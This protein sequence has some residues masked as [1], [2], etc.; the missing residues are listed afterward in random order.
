M[1]AAKNRNGRKVPTAATLSAAG[2]KPLGDSVADAPGTPAIAI[3]GVGAS[4][5]GLEALEELFHNMP[6]GTGIAFVVITHLH[7]GHESLLPELLARI[8]DVPV[9]AAALFG[10]RRDG[11]RLHRVQWVLLNRSGHEIPILLTLTLLTGEQGH[12]DAIAMV[13]TQVSQ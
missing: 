11:E 9:V 5:G 4:A 10:R 6:A 2:D 1:A 13:T 8:T 7:P 12:V 3:A